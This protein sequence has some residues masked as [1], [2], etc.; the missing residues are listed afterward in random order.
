MVRGSFVSFVIY[1]DMLDG[2]QVFR[3]PGSRSQVVLMRANR[4]QPQFSNISTA[5]SPTNSPANASRWKRTITR[6]RERRYSCGRVHVHPGG[7]M[8]R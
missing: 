8:R 6:C 1:L 3:S 5:T 2:A 4:V 7:G